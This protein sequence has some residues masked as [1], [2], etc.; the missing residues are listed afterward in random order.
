MKICM[1]SDKQSCTTA[2]SENKR[3]V[4]IELLRVMATIAVIAIHVAAQ[5]FYS[6]EI[7]SLEWK[8]FNITDSA[9]RWAVPVF[10]MISGAL[11]L[12]HRKN[13]TIKSIY[14]KNIRK[15]VIVFVF[16]SAFY[17]LNRLI[18]G[19]GLK[20]AVA[21]F[22]EGNYHLW[23]LFMIC[24]LYI[25]VPILRK[26]TVTKEMTEYFLVVGL[27]FTFIIPR[28]LHLLK[29]VE[30]PYT[31]T[32]TDSLEA[33]VSSMKFHLTLGYVVYFVLGYYL[34][35]YE[36]SKKIQRSLYVLGIAGFVSIAVLTMWYSQ[37]QMKAYTAFYDNLSVG[38]LFMSVAVFVFAKYRL[39]QIKWN[40]KILSAVQK[41]SN[42]SLGIYL[43]HV[44]VIEKLN[45]WAA[46]HTL[47]FHPI[48]SVIAMIVCVFAVSY[49]ISGAL[50][51][52]P[53]LSKYI[54]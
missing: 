49:M 51:R 11:F 8:V 52:I 25:V 39:D 16:W 41:I 1:E 33:A 37:K 50:H 34:S 31:K 23:F 15:I 42:H 44:F 35:E 5:N 4:Y 18:C 6:V 53:V 46:F 14:T 27:V 24:G 9:V 38:V 12:N 3:I 28:T 2:Q 29:C 22:I 21:S 48:V 43:V 10:V 13:I 36:I 17:A 20:K 32:V 7:N 45:K 26:I 30:L 40:D 47:T 19:E 54:V